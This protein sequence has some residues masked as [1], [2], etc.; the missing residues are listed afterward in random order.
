MLPDPS[1]PAGKEAPGALELL[2]RFCNSTNPENGAERFRD[3]DQLDAWLDGR[4]PQRRPAPTG[5][6]SPG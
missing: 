5:P 3:A 4:G 6:G 1:W 2:R